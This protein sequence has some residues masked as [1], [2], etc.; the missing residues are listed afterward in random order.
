MEYDRNNDN[1]TNSL[2]SLFPTIVGE[3]LARKL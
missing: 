1:P 3:R 2:S